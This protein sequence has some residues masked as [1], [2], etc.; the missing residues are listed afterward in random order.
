M[1]EKKLTVGVAQIAPVWLQRDATLQKVADWIAGAAAEGC[2]LVVFGEALVPGYPFWVEST[3]GVRRRP[4][5]KT[6]DLR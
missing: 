2:D 6:E 1:T 3:D 5:S 4:N